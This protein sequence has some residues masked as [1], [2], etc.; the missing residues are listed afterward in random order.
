[1]NSDDYKV[2]IIN[3]IASEELKV[4]GIKFFLLNLVLL[5]K[6]KQPSKQ[7]L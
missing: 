5:Y 1:L 3:T 7:R 4:E 6:R 2:K